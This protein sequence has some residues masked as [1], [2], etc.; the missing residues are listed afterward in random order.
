MF[1]IIAPA[2]QIAYIVQEM[3]ME[4]QNAHNVKLLFHTSMMRAHTVLAGA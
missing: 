1:A 2:I 3:M 4:C